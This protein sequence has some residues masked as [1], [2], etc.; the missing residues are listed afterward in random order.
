MQIGGGLMIESKADFPENPQGTAISTEL[1][2]YAEM[3]RLRVA[4]K[5]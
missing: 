5:V 2:V 3:P 1:P 4:L